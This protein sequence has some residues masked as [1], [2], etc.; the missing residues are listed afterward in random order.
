MLFAGCGDK[1]KISKD[2]VTADL[3]IESVVTDSN[4]DISEGNV[5]FIKGDFN[6]A[7][8]FYQQAMRQNKAVALYNIGVSYYLLKDLPKAEQNFLEAVETD[9]SFEEAVMNLVSVLAQQEKIGEA[10]KYLTTLI[11]TNKSARVYVDMAN[12]ALKTNQPAKAAYYYKDALVIEPNSPY[13]LSNYANFLISIGAYQDGIDILEQFELKDFSINYNLANA[14][15]SMKDYA[16]ALGYGRQALNSQGGTEEGYN[17]LAYL[18]ADL[19][20]FADEAQTLRVLISRYPKRDYKIRLVNSYVSGGAYE[21][22]LDELYPLLMEY[23]NDIPLHVLNYE[24]LIFASKTQEAGS[25]IRALYKRIPD[26]A[27][28]YYYVKHLSTFERKIDEVRPLIFVNRE[29]GWLN[30]A[31]TVYSLHKNNY[32]EAKRY[33]A[34]SP[35]SVG[36]DYYAYKTFLEIKDKNFKT[37]RITADKMDRYKPDFFWYRLVIAWNLGEGDIIAALADEYKSNPVVNVR[38]PYLSFTLK[39]QLADMSFTYRFDDAGIDV[40]SMLAYPIFIEPDPIVQFLFLGNTTL[41]DSEKFEATKKLEGIKRNN[42]GVDAF[43]ASDFFTALK[44]FSEAAEML[45]NNPYVAYNSGLAHFNLGDNE[46][47]LIE[48][49]NSTKF[50]G[51]IPQGHLGLGLVNY[52]LGNRSLSIVNF[53]QSIKMALML[54]DNIAK[55]KIDDIRY[56][57]LCVLASDRKNKRNETTVI[58][59]TDDAF[60]AAVISLMDYFDNNFDTAVLSSLQNSP[61]FRVSLVRDLLLMEHLKPNDYINIDSKDRYYTLAKQYIMLARGGRAANVF[62]E[63]FAKDKVYL[64]D[65]VYTSVYLN[66]KAAGLRYLQTLTNI[67]YKYAGLYKASLYYFTWIRDFVNAEASYGSLDR[68]GYRDQMTDFYMLLYFLTNYNEERLRVMLKIYEDSYGSDYRSGVVTALMNLNIK[69]II[70]FSSLINSLIRNNTD[71]FDKIFVEVNFE[72]F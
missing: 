8:K 62:N 52:K 12:I 67:D 66:D 5:S 24:V 13:V 36:H 27:V 26:D 46:K 58:P 1:R 72:Q 71:L 6:T 51:D 23:P 41:R 30:L 11:R 57:Y 19:K 4:K 47:A 14:Y 54:V 25:F 15:F 48:F 53:E 33:L 37:A 60:V 9:P 59:E 2:E 43:Y 21:T 68:S 29:S 22:A 70:V 65:K 17:K 64:K 44:K 35:E 38:L 69:N 7:I 16:N 61:V 31:R 63:R 55:P 50:S 20:Q 10:E 28:L 34:K 3:P 42:E 39:P 40:A 49:S 56:F 32:P 18:F 45:P